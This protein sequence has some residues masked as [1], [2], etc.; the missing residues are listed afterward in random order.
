MRF[1]SCFGLNLAAQHFFGMGGA[2]VPDSYAKDFVSSAPI[3]KSP[4]LASNTTKWA[5]YTGYVNLV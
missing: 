1:E 4:G 5:Q 2:C 3:C